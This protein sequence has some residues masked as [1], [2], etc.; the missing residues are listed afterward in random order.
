MTDQTVDV[1]IVG[2]G[3]AGL[4]AAVTLAEAGRTDVVILE[5]GSSVGGTWRDNTYPGCACDVQSHLY[6]FSF[7]PN[8]DWTR[9]F[10]RQPEIRAYLES[11]VDRY[12]LR[13]KLRFGR[14]V[15]AMEWDGARW[16]VTTAD[17]SVVHARAV[18]W[19]TGPLHLPST[20]E[21]EGVEEFRGTVFHSSRWDHDHDL[22]GRRVAV[23]GTG[24]SAIQFVPHIQREVASL[25]LFQRTAPWVLPK[26]DRPIPA[27]VRA[28]YRRIPLAQRI[29]RSL[30]YARNEM[31]VGGF[32]KPARM[33]VIEAFARL[34]LDRTFADRP[35]LKAKLTPDFTIGCKR[36]LM[37]N[38]Y[39]SALKQ[40]NVDVVTDGITRVT[41]T[42]VVTADGVEH[43][44]DTIIFG[45][46]FRVGESLRDVAVTGRDGVKLA[47]E[48]ADGPQAHLGTTV[49]GFPNLFLM[50]GPNTGLGHS[51][52][53]FMIESQTR[54]ILDALALL[55]AHG[56]TAIDTR[57]DRQDAFNAE[58]QRRLQGSVWNSG[59]CKSWYLD[60]HGN[61]RTVWPGY[62]FDYRRRL[63]KVHRADHELVS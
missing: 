46:G 25:T 38:D 6:S 57:R 10:A 1:A 49:A 63:R 3:F 2:S 5:K 45:T 18:V 42:G 8:P 26:P 21:I 17:G 62:T 36:I 4:G 11:V 9:T 56:A 53:V 31:L 16:A 19:G 39:Y 7:A 34:H 33:K 50:I 27:L 37:S 54:F 43:E 60:A 32:L 30:V 20:P 61:N 48:W 52:M 12:D 58:V 59:G 44:V 23:I 14:E 55:D 35:D 40:P 22:R 51:S 24:A 28:L 47:D 41:P 29:Q 15:T 13:G